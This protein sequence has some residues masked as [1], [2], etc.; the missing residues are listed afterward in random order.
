M[1]ALKY[2]NSIQLL[3]QR[4]KKHTHK[5]T[6]QPDQ[7][8]GVGVYDMK[9]IIEKKN[10]VHPSD[11]LRMEETKIQSSQK[12]HQFIGSTVIKKDINATQTP[13]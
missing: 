11:I 1:F 10:H 12:Q 8:L 7:R 2:P 9:K 13:T 3:G 5:K 6:R 4:V